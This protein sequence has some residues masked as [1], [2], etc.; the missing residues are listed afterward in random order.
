MYVWRILDSERLDN[1][2]S[3]RDCYWAVTS[4]CRGSSVSPWIAL[5][6]SLFSR[7]TYTLQHFRISV[8]LA[9][10]LRTGRLGFRIPSS[11]NY[12]AMSWQALGINQ[13]HIPSVSGIF[14]EGVGKRHWRD[15]EHPLPSSTE[16]KIGWSYTSAPPT[17]HDT[18]KFTFIYLRATSLPCDVAH[19]V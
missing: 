9:T 7:I 15:V 14:P 5:H 3:L 8:G 2:R 6:F 11:A 1:T 16:N 13:P 10:R 12:S 17:R 18:N 19:R 4:I